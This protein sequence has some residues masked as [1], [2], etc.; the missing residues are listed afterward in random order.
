MLRR[1]LHYLA[2]VLLVLSMSLP[3]ASGQ[4]NSPLPSIDRGVKG[5]PAADEKSSSSPSALSYFALAIYAML[6]LTI[7][8]MPSRKA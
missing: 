4:T 3:F 6:I 7:V 8:C 2:A 5:E 1:F